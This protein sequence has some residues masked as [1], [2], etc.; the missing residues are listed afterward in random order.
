M[1]DLRVSMLV[2]EVEAEDRDAWW[3]IGDMA[4]V[5]A[6]GLDPQRYEPALAGL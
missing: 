4:A 2:E 1:Y 3:W 5:A 6:Q